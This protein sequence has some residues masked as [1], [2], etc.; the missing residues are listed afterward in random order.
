VLRNQMPE[1][2]HLARSAREHGAVAA[3]AFGA[4]FGGAVWAMIPRDDADRFMAV[5]RAN[6]ERAFPS[7][8]ARAKWAT[9][10]AAGAARRVR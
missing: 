10:Q 5:W 4:G 1:T 3:S 2:I 6:Y 7:R 8:R 9:T